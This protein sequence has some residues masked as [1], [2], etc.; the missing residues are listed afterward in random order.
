MGTDIHGVFQRKDKNT[1]KWHGV[2]STYEQERHYQL[3]AVLAGVRNG[4]GFAGVTTGSPVKP[5]SE[6]RGLPLDFQIDEQDCHQIEVLEHMDPRR[7]QWHEKDD[8]LKVWMGDHSYSWL[9]G[10]EMLA[11]VENAPTVTKTGILAR[12]VYEA[13]DGTTTPLSYCG[14]ISGPNVVVVND[15]TVDKDQCPNWTHIRCYWE[16][17]LAEELAYFF[18]EIKRLVE[19][20]GEV[21]FVF[22]FDS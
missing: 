2:S 18:D 4:T 20:H 22:G 5:I 15:N 9:S 17:N 10:E 11:W 19:E 3:F 1:G 13:W 16:S 14:G 6:P 21:R 12:D 8:S 7:R